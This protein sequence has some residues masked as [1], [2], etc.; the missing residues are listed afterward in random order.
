MDADAAAPSDAALIERAK[1][2]PEAFGVLYERH[3]QSV[4]A[5]VFSKVRDRAQAED[6]TSQTFLQALRALPRYQQR[7]VPIRSWFF[8][9]AANL[10]TD[11]HRAPVA[12]Q[13]LQVW[14]QG[15]AIVASGRVDAASAG[16]DVVAFDPPDPR[17]EAEI[18]AWESAEDF[19]RLIVDLTPEQRTVLQLRFAE[20]LAIAEIARQMDRSEGAVKMLMMR[21]LQQLRR[22]WGTEAGHD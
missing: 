21:G 12:M 5:F 2:D 16:S 6:I 15:Q 19:L 10:V 22:R 14:Q 3:V 4:F 11:L 17:A 7:G 18:A 1:N 20:G 9:I 8:R 13:P